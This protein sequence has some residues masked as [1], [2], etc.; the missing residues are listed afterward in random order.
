MNV[1]ATPASGSPEAPRATT[2]TGF[3]NTQEKHVVC[4]VLPGSAWSVTAWDAKD[5]K[6]S[7]NVAATAVHRFI[8]RFREGMYEYRR[9]G[10]PLVLPSEGR[11][12]RRDVDLLH[13]HH[14]GERALG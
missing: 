5:H 13:L 4:G 9:A 8:G 6:A 2:P 12:Q 7:V 10:G 1:T 14:R 11:F 3:G